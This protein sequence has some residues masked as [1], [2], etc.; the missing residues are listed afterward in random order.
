MAA[1]QDPSRKKAKSK[2]RLAHEKA[3]ME[4]GQCFLCEEVGHHESVCRKKK[5]VP[6][7][8]RNSTHQ[9]TFYPDSTSPPAQ[10]ESP[11]FRSFPVPMKSSST[12]PDTDPL[13][14]VDPSGEMDG[15]ECI[16]DCGCLLTCRVYEN[17]CIP[18][19]L[20]R[21][22]KERVCAAFLF[23]SSIPSAQAAIDFVTLFR[24]ESNEMLLTLYT[25]AG[26]HPNEIPRKIS[27]SAIQE[28]LEKLRSLVARHCS[29][30]VAIGPCGLDLAHSFSAPIGPQ[31]H[32]LKSQIELANQQCLPLLVE[33]VGAS[34][35]LVQI[36]TD[37]QPIFGLILMLKIDKELPQSS[38]CLSQ[39]QIEE[40]S[41][42][43]A[44]G[45]PFW[46]AVSGQITHDLSADRDKD[47]IV[48]VLHRFAHNLLVYS[49]GPKD[50]PQNIT[51]SQIRDC[52]PNEP[53]N[54]PY[55]FQYLAD[56]S[57]CNL[58]REQIIRS[59]F[60]NSLKAFRLSLLHV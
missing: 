31:R 36:L 14:S 12:I 17:A 34:S 27:P 51:D 37:L 42:A 56:P 48:S 54:L 20:Q 49:G 59:I 60:S 11:P 44:P 1:R 58:P 3:L 18:R 33:C 41:A 21:A 24:H 2:K 45:C 6:K 13:H 26:V 23:G 19:V 43:L 5:Q 50:T 32:F 25:T 29:S 28:E 9:K 57:V 40:I 39:S 4:G 8:S 47:A 15:Q 7:K 38:L 55:L 35:E 10:Q 30:I 46:L 22:A 53:S 52:L 16:I